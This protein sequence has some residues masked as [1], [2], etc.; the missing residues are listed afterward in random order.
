MLLDIAE[1]NANLKDKAP[2]ER[3]VPQY[4]NYFQR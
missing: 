1:G 3:F 2:Y 4:A